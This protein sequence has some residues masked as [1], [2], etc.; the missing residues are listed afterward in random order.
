MKRIYH[1]YWLWE[2]YKAGFYDNISGRNKVELGNYVIELFNNPELTEVYM[3]KVIQ[4]WK[5]SCEHNL[6]N[7]SLNRIA[8]L[9]QAACCIYAKVPFNITMNAWNK[10][11]L[12]YRVIADKIALKIINE[13]EQNHKLQNTLRNGNEK[14]MKMEY[15]M[16]LQMN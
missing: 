15:Q 3:S 10:L 14:D 12:Y 4:E 7:I 8:Y 9:G 11:D 1:P 5:Y 16:K 6:T 13:W 2:D